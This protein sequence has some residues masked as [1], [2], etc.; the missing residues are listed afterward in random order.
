MVELLLKRMSM[1]NSIEQVPQAF[2]CSENRSFQSQPK[3]PRPTVRFKAAILAALK[4]L[5][6]STITF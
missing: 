5:R 6:H 2:E 1:T 3:P 4:S